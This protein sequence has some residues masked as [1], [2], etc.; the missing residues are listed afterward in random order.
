MIHKKLFKSKTVLTVMCCILALGLTHCSDSS[1]KTAP[2]ETIVLSSK[3][4]GSVSSS[5]IDKSK[6]ATIDPG[7]C[8]G[9]SGA[10]F[11]VGGLGTALGGEDNQ[12]TVGSD[13]SFEF[14][15]PETDEIVADFD[16]A[17]KAG[18]DT[19]RCF[20]KSGSTDL[21][22]DPISN[23]IVIALE[24]S[25]GGSVTSDPLF[26]GL[27]VAKIAEGMVET[28][29][30]VAQIDPTAD[31]IGALE[32]ATDM[33][34]ILA[35][36]EASPVGD[37]FSSIKALADEQREINV[38]VVPI[39][40][41]FYR[42]QYPMERLVTMLTSLG[43]TV[44][45]GVD[46]ESEDGPGSVYDDLFTSIDTWANTDFVAK[47]RAYLL[48]LYTKL[49]V[50]KETSN[51]AMLCYARKD[52]GG[53]NNI[54]LF[55]PI[56][57]PNDATKLTCLGNSE[58]TDPLGITDATGDIVQEWCEG[59]QQWEDVWRIGL[60]IRASNQEL[61]RND[62]EGKY[63]KDDRVEELEIGVIDVFQEFFAAMMTPV[64]DGGCG[65]HVNPACFGDGDG[66]CPPE[67][68]FASGFNTCIMGI[69]NMD[70]YYAG[71]L[72]IY[73]FMTLGELR[74]QKFSLNQLYTAFVDPVFMGIRLGADLW[75]F[76]YEY[77]E[78]WFH[79]EYY[80]EF[81]GKTRDGEVA[82]WMFVDKTGQDGIEGN[83]IQL[84]C[85]EP[86]CTAEG[87]P[88]PD[89][90]ENP[91]TS[92][93]L[94]EM[95]ALVDSSAP[96]YQTTMAM[97][98]NI[99]TM[100]QIK[101]SIFGDAH[102]EPYNIAGPSK[103]YVR[104]GVGLTG[105][106]WDA[107]APIL[108]NIV[109]PNAAGEFV[110]GQSTISCEVATG[111][112]T[113]GKPDPVTME[114]YKRYYA[115]M[116]RSWSE[117]G[118]DAYFG[119]MKLSNGTE[120]WLNGRDFRVRVINELRISDAVTDD[121][122]DSGIPNTDKLVAGDVNSTT[123]KK[124]DRERCDT[125]TDDSGNMET[126][127][128][129]E[130]FDYV[131]IAIPDSFY[132][133]SSYY[134]Y[135]RDIPFEDPET[136]DTW[137]M[138]IAITDGGTPGVFDDDVPVC[139]GSGV[140][141]DATGDSILDPHESSGIVGTITQA[142]LDAN[143][144]NCFTTEE[145]T[146]YYLQP[147]WGDSS[148]RNLFKYGLIRNDGRGMYSSCY[149]EEGIPEPICGN[150]DGILLNDDAGNGIE[151]AVQTFAPSAS[152]GPSAADSRLNGYEVA[153]FSH[154]A[155]Y[156]PYCDDVN[157]NGYCDCV[158]IDTTGDTLEDASQCT[159]ENGADPNEPT[160]SELPFWHES[161]EAKHIMAWIDQFGG[162][163]GKTLV[164][165]II[166]YIDAEDL[167]DDPDQDG[168]PSNDIGSFTMDN[169][170]AEWHKLFECVDSTKTIDGVDM[171]RISNPESYPDIP[172]DEFNDPYY[173]IASGCGDERIDDMG[174]PEDPSDDYSWVVNGPVR[175]KNLTRR[176]N[177]YDI[178]RPN[179]LVKL[180]S[181]ATATVGTGVTIDPDAQ[182]FSFQEALAL[183][184]VRTSFPI[185]AEFQRPDG[186]S[187]DGASVYFTE[188]KKFGMGSE[189]PIS[190]LLRAF[191]EANGYIDPYTPPATK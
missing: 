47:F 38:S 170:H 94:A 76:G 58:Y 12:A 19:I 174:T 100:E 175:L 114:K 30:L 125:W 161:S 112:W 147:W 18:I 190:G 87:V 182:V 134:P 75:Q 56:P 119:L 180:I 146:F 154:D 150:F 159:L 41:D 64:A 155:K 177:A 10:V 73:N 107:Q 92:V 23:A 169:I 167:V 189:D 172:G 187:L 160:L 13:G 11:L 143:I 117:Y 61:N 78:S 149:W 27:S 86:V 54:T 158:A 77:G 121:S 109:D 6:S 188:A 122:A 28:L 35:I 3:I 186:T 34:T 15:T 71:L 115:L 132:P 1:K 116:D 31:L 171:W 20:G 67:G 74:E 25:V 2:A 72:G 57:R 113:N 83:V 88:I 8:S 166:A 32:A 126:N 80:D 79:F 44:Q 16:C 85:P 52:N 50:N 164:D 45:V 42:E 185:N 96:T 70:R 40:D 29:K 111:T 37:T 14:D 162:Q 157:N 62:L 102:H 36:I 144:V 68:P 55:P 141:T 118:Y 90:W 63:S 163:T 156:D 103:F 131:A 84:T 152:M 133:P 49:Y 165:S 178:A 51:V 128:W 123:V 183:L 142:K 43:I 151:P 168:D 140:M 127:C 153:N 46:E 173:Y 138:Q 104:G 48:E 99:P 105:N 108:C 33:E 89:T 106:E 59:C 22:C 21:I 95:Q 101:Q 130:M 17:T 179:T 66:E 181:A 9:A 24:E 129:R 93:T 139:L 176:N 4:S 81:E 148:D 65:D 91:S 39:T 110:I 26:R 60:V 53:D 191:L 5:S 97:F 82:S 136:G 137:N 120:Y 145:Q 7:T 135:T 184:M 98:E 69:E 124:I